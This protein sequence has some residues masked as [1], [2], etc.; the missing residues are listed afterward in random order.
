MKKTP[1]KPEAWNLIEQLLD[2]F[3]KAIRPANRKDYDL[4]PVKEILQKKY[5]EV[6]ANPYR[7]IE[8]ETNRHLSP[9]RIEFPYDSE[10][11]KAFDVLRKLTHAAHKVQEALSGKMEQPLFFTS[12]HVS[13]CA[14]Q[15]LLQQGY[16][17]RYNFIQDE[18]FSLD[19]QRGGEDERESCFVRS[20]SSVYKRYDYKGQLNIDLTA[21]R[22]TIGMGVLQMMEKKHNRPNMRCCMFFADNDATRQV[23][24]RYIASLKKA[25]FEIYGVQSPRQVTGY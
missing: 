23:M 12:T 13:A 22:S 24:L 6:Y 16:E 2:D 1:P 4:G 5:P 15:W 20:I 14:K 17:V 10:L 19:A 8:E 21:V 3:L 7:L 11:R 18:I 25:E 9:W